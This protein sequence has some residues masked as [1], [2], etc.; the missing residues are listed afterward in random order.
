MDNPNHVFFICKE[1]DQA[2][3]FAKMKIQSL[4]RNFSGLRQSEL[5]KIYVIEPYWGTGAGEALMQAVRA[6]VLQIRPDLVW[7][8]VL[9]QNERAIRFYERCG[10]TREGQRFFTIGTQVFEYD[11]MAMAGQFLPTNDL[12]LTKHTSYGIA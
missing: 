8:D 3:G 12:T 7:L 2:V 5:Q 4:N 9:V 10:F 1:K 6:S 11:I